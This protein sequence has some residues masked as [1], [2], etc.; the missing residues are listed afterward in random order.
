METAPTLTMHTHTFASGLSLSS[1]DPNSSGTKLN[2]SS[3]NTHHKT[4]M[5]NKLC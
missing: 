3:A 1:R 5:L 2:S 4:N